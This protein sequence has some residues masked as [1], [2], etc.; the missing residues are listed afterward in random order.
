M[1]SNKNKDE[2]EMHMTWPPNSAQWY[3]NIQTIQRLSHKNNNTIY[4][5][6]HKHTQ[7]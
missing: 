5:H 7:N 3:D 1:Y 4:I 2:A 6:T